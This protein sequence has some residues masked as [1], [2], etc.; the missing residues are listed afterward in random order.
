M[1]L[2]LEAH[3]ALFKFAQENCNITSFQPYNLLWNLG[4]SKR[5][6]AGL[7]PCMIQLIF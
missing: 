3:E 5:S 1:I 2:V 7:N 6:K 4:M